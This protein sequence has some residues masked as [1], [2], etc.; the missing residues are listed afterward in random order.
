[1]RRGGPILE[2]ADL[3]LTIA[4]IAVAF[5]GFA[6]LVSA[7]SSAPIEEH[8]IVQSVRFRTM[9][10]MSL[11]VVAFSLVPFVPHGLGVPPA[12]SWRIASGLFLLSGSAGMY[13]GF[14]NLAGTRAAV[15]R[16]A[17]SNI[18]VAV[19]SGAASV[20]LLLLG[21]NTLGLSSTFAPGSYVAALL[22]YLLG[23]GTA[24]AALLFSYIHPIPKSPSA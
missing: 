17:G 10:L 19:V 15:G 12:L 4:E 21:A 11:T 2:N 22:L 9:V 16:D 24:F 6:S 1:M 8:P 5:A 7:L 14:R 23:S 18:R 3:L 20:A 13:T